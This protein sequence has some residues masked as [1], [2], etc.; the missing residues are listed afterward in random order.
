MVNISFAASQLLEH[1]PLTSN[2]RDL[3]NLTSTHWKESVCH[4]DDCMI[5][6]HM[7]IIT[8]MYF[9]ALTSYHLEPVFSY[10]HTHT[11][12]KKIVTNY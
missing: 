8:K 5:F 6:Q 11:H 2:R 7:W 1:V 4:Y 12:T 9:G 3:A 10:T